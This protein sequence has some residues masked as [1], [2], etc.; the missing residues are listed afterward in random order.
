MTARPPTR[1]RPSSRHA[2]GAPFWPQ[3][4]LRTRPPRA[5]VAGFVI[6]L[7]NYYRVWA[8]TRFAGP[9]RQGTDAELAEIELEFE[10]AARE[11]GT[12]TP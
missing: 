6:L 1:P 11:L 4:P 5:T 2:R 9:R 7:A 10:R 12:A 3:P 8:R